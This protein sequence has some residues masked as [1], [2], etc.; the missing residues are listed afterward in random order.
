MNAF[1]LFTCTCSGSVSFKR[2]I[3]RFDAGRDT[4]VII[5]VF[6]YCVEPHG[7]LTLFQSTNNRIKTNFSTSN[8]NV[9]AK[10]K[11]FRKC[12]VNT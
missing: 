2:V 7:S 3:K 11:C 12:L 8:N 6:V 4:F 5:F 9:T 10:K 1:F